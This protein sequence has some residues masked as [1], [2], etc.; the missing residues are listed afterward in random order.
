MNNPVKLTDV[1]LVALIIL[2][3]L[4]FMWSPSPRLNNSDKPFVVVKIKTTTVYGEAKYYGKN[5]SRALSRQR[6]IILPVG[7]YNLGD[8]IILKK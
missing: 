5:D 8:T 7:L 3:I 6:P 1:L 4:A 2:M